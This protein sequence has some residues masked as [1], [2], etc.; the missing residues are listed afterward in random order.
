VIVY[1]ERRSRAIEPDPTGPETSAYIATYDEIR[2]MKR[3]L[4][5]SDIPADWALTRKRLEQL[6]VV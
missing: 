1:V 3:V 4:R 5:E 6:G 2:A